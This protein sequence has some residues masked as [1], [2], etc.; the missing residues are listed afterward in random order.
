MEF[1]E[2]VG[3]GDHSPFILC[4]FAETLVAKRMPME[5][6]PETSASHRNEITWLAASRSTSLRAGSRL[7]TGTPIQRLKVCLPGGKSMDVA[8]KDWL[9][10]SRFSCFNRFHHSDNSRQVRCPS[11]VSWLYSRKENIFLRDAQDFQ[12]SLVTNPIAAINIVSVSR[13]V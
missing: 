9:R 5:R 4:R 8:A 6:D 13:P 2:L 3:G 12:S 11:H 7:G 10:H 1:R